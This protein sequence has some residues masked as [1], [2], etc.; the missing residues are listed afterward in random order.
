M[1]KTYSNVVAICEIFRFFVKN[2]KSYLIYHQ[3]ENS[4]SPKS[5]ESSLQAAVLLLTI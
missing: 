3:A 4:V 2:D 5:H 1:K